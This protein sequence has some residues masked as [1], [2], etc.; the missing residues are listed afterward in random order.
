M[1]V[2]DFNFGWGDDVELRKFERKILEQYLHP[3][4]LDDSRCITINSTWY[5]QQCHQEVLAYLEHHSIDRIVLVSCMDPAIPQKDWFSDTGSIVRCTGYYPGPDEID[6]WALIVNQYFDRNRS[7]EHDQIDTAFLCYNRKP[8]HHRRALVAR[9]QA[10]G[11]VSKGVVT[12]GHESGQ[13]QFQLDHDVSGSDIAPN[14]GMDQYGIANDIM[15]LGPQQ[16]WNRCFL[17]IVTETVFDVDQQWF[18]SEKIYKPILGL[19]PFLVYAPGGAQKWLDHIGLHNFMQDFQDITDLD[20][21]DPA[22]CAPFLKTLCDQGPDYLRRKYIALQ[23]KIMHNREIFDDHVSR[24]LNKISRG[25][26]T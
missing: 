26:T 20:L 6:I 4:H 22:S 19:R 12:L 8:H 11:C 9:L 13:A 24:T 10:A 15:S 5:S 23:D 7:V 2:K 14:P 1:I 25:I 18:V 17:N 3:W 16:I 21:S